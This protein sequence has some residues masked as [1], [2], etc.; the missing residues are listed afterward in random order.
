MRH[1]K[2]AV[3]LA[4]VLACGVGFFLEA[5]LLR[6]SV[7]AGPPLVK[8]ATQNGAGSVINANID[9]TGTCYWEIRPGSDEIY[10]IH[11]ML[12]LIG[13]VGAPDADSYGNNITI[14]PGLTVTVVEG[15]GAGAT[16]LHTLTDVA[17]TT[18]SGWS[19]YA[20]DVAV[21]DFGTGEDFV[22]V[23]WTFSKFGKPLCL[24]GRR[25]QALRISLFDDYSG[26]TSHRFVV[27][28]EQ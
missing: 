25:G 15:T 21:D 7:R 17:I 13:D 26:L 20:Y 28:G 19:S 10:Y 1:R 2:H 14:S 18:N 8:H 6:P 5:V 4:A 22:K 27:E 16:V 3:A 12:V 11:R 23:R 9:C 24:D